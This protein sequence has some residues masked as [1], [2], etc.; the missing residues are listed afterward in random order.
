MKEESDMN[1]LN[2][3][4][5]LVLLASP[6]WQGCMTANLWDSRYRNVTEEYAD[7]DVLGV[8]GGRPPQPGRQPRVVVHCRLVDLETAN[9]PDWIPFEG[10]EGWIAIQAPED[11]VRALADGMEEMLALHC[12]SVASIEGFLHLDAGMGHAD[13]AELVLILSTD[14]AAD[15]LWTKSFVLRGAWF[16]ADTP[17]DAAVG[18]LILDA[19]P[20]PSSFC[21]IRREVDTNE[22]LLVALTPLTLCLDGAIIA[23]SAAEAAAKVIAVLFPFR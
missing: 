12:H 13:G 1:T 16:S 22:G 5:A 18:R 10:P 3:A 7:A 15:R 14:D 23:I 11:E 6:L 19:R 21:L 20:W 4:L 17:N 2:R 9:R 8:Y